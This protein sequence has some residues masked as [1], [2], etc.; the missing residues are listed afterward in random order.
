MPYLSYLSVFC[1]AAPT[2]NT[3]IYD[4]T[5]LESRT[6]AWVPRV[7]QGLPGY[8][9][10]GCAIGSPVSFL[11]SLIRRDFCVRLRYFCLPLVYFFPVSTPLLPLSIYSV[12]TIKYLQKKKKKKVKKNPRKSAKKVAKATVQDRHKRTISRN[13]L[14]SE[15]GT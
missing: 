11:R 2:E 3:S 7:V 4:P 8:V 10:V 6:R 1:P 14:Q 5:L 15:S 13:L 12:R 9:A